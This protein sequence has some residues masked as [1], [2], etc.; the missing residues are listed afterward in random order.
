MK[1]LLILAF[2]FSFHGQAQSI[3]CPSDATRVF[4]PVIASESL[5]P[6]VVLDNHFKHQDEKSLGPKEIKHF[7]VQMQKEL[8][9][10]SVLEK[11]AVNELKRIK[12]LDRSLEK[13]IDHLKIVNEVHQR[14]IARLKQQTAS[15]AGKL[16]KFEDKYQDQLS[17]RYLCTTH[18]LSTIKDEVRKLK[19]EIIS[20]EKRR[21]EIDKAFI[22]LQKS[23]FRR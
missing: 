12:R 3:I 18:D 21:K 14:I 20:Q 2:L 10:W 23:F 6:F 17:E 9:K 13:R 16:K 15:K 4:S 8:L 22:Q 19:L 5:A 1:C 11:N 7:K